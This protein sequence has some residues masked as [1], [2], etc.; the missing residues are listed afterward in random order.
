MPTCK[1]PHR[2]SPSFRDLSDDQGG[3]GRHGCAGCAYGDGFF[4]GM[5]QTGP[6]AMNLSKFPCSQAGTVR[7]KSPEEAWVLGYLRGFRVVHPK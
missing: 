3:K 4:S 7:H 5:C 6:K 2:Y 1:K